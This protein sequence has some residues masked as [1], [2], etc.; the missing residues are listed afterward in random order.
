MFK[1]LNI[2]LAANSNANWDFVVTQLECPEGTSNIGAPKQATNSWSYTI[3]ERPEELLT[4][5]ILNTKPNME[6]YYWLGMDCL[7]KKNVLFTH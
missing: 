7:I 3:F 5:T 2:L 6:D 4:R 1:E